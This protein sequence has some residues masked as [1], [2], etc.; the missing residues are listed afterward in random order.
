MLR[1]NL[2]TRPFYNERAVHVV[3]GLAALVVLALTVVNLVEVVR[4]SRQNTG[5]A[6]RIRDD[7]SAADDLSRR[8]R[9]IRQGIDQNELK[10]VVAAAQEA[11][12]LIDGRTFSW[13]GLFNQLESTLPP[14]VML[15]SVRPKIDD[16]AT[17]ITMIVL[18][19]RTSDLDEFM[20]KLEATGAFENV[21]P[22]Q[23]NLNDD[24]LTQVTI[25][26]LYV[27]ETPP[28][29][30]T[31][32]P[33][34]PAKA[35]AAA[36]GRC[37][38]T[39]FRRVLAEKRGFIYPLVGAVLLNAAVFIAVVYPL[40]LKVANGERDAQAA[41]RARA[42]AQ[43]E[44]DRARATVSGKASAD[45]ELKKFYSAVLPPDQSAARRIIY[46]KIDKLAS[47]ASVKPGQETFAPS[48]ERGSQLGKL[49]ATVVLMGEYR[50][51]R[52]FIHDLET[53]PEFLILENVALSQ[54]SER[55]RGLTV[56]VK[57]ATYFRIGND[58]T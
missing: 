2:S 27:P 52:R 35:A 55:D 6:G 33:A 15:A 21:L 47:T 20:E 50:N 23:Q 43:A 28:A 46:G 29:A 56:V 42:T 3:V 37:P 38:M 18:G 5:L 25:E 10:V 41:S 44:F 40:S 9:Q 30:T 12:T 54:T 4:L 31:T 57:V 1:T 58:G 19:R 24:G 48:Q 36:A 16:G 13:T 17:T 49:T 14:E 32:A 39:I 22:L 45:A 8:A 34:P 53:A 7:R 11:N 51:I 26:A